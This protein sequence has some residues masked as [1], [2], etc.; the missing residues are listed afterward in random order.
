L[1]STISVFGWVYL[2]HTPPSPSSSSNSL[3]ITT[4]IWDITFGLPISYLIALLNKSLLT[5]LGYEKLM[6]CPSG[7]FVNRML[8]VIVNLWLVVGWAVQLIEEERGKR[9][10]A[11]GE[12]IERWKGIVRKLERERERWYELEVR[13]PYSFT[14][15]RG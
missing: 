11:R 7:I 13:L 14:F 15:E 6:R 2:P 4:V 10:K 5:L 9:I 8:M 1:I 12:E 3:L